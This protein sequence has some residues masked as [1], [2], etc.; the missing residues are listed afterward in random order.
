MTTKDGP[1]S[2]VE[3][4]IPL[5]AKLQQAE[6][7]SPVPPNCRLYIMYPKLELSCHVDI[8]VFMECSIALSCH[9]AIDIL[10]SKEVYG[11]T[12][13]SL[14]LSPLPPRKASI[15][16]QH[17]VQVRSEII[18]N[19]V[20]LWEVRHRHLTSISCG[21]AVCGCV[22]LPSVTLCRCITDNASLTVMTRRLF[23]GG[24]YVLSPLCG[25]P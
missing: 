21:I 1:C 11:C 5:M 20:K 6:A 23:L 13:M 8:G 4:H 12:R 2:P 10:R 25:L 15:G 3:E 14:Q 22:L 17:D 9:V 24:T 18:M 19:W 7:P 16:P